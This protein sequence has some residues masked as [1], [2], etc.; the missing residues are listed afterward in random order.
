LSCSLLSSLFVLASAQANLIWSETFDYSDGALASVS[1]GNWTAYGGGTPAITVSGNKVVGMLADGASRPDAY[2]ALGTEYSSGKM[3]AGFD[4]RLMSEPSGWAYF[5]AFYR[6]SSGT[7]RGRVFAAAPSAP[8]SGFRFGI[9][10]QHGDG[11]ASVI[12]SGDYALNTTYRVV[13]GWDFT[14]RTSQLWIA[15]D[16]ELAPTLTDS[17][18]APNGLAL[19]ALLLRQGGTAANTYS[20]LSLDNLRVAT[21]FAYAVPEPHEYALFAGLGLVGFAL[22]RRRAAK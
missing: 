17:T 7:A 3:F 14:T 8:G 1:G 10:N 21:D 15:S 11:A 4:F 18:D 20:G 12:L 16:D 6:T 19:N 5:L 13:F 22:W 2:R 9:E